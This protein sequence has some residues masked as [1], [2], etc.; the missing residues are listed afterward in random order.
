MG[1]HALSSKASDFTCVPLCHKHHV[2]GRDSVHQLGPQKFEEVHNVDLKELQIR[3]LIRYLAE[4]LNQDED[5][6]S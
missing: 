3:F 4:I 2:A 5:A 1:S 6:Q